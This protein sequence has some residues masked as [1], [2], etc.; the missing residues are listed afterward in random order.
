MPTMPRDCTHEPALL[1]VDARGLL[2]P[3]CLRALR[4]VASPTVLRST[5]EIDEA[6]GDARVAG[7]IVGL[8]EDRAGLAW[9]A[10]ARARGESIPVMV[11]SALD[12][13]SVA[14]DAFRLDAQLVYAPL[15]ARNATLFAVR[16]AAR[17]VEHEA[18][19]EAVVRQLCVE[20]GLTAREGEVAT[21]AAMGVSRAGL[22]SSL[23][24][25]ENS[26]KVYVRGL[27][28]NLGVPSVEAAGRLVLEI[29]VRTRS[30]QAGLAARRGRER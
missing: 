2:E 23:G 6:L 20:R 3:R 26:V 5:K 1:V 8:R 10:S 12:E 24:V 30:Q 16:A 21:L 27:L 15:D 14:N 7:A 18:R 11:V 25:S 13:R 28:R 9:L 17:R 29:V 19:V 4:A 22:A